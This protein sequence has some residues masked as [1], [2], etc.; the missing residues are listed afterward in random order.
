M[1][2]LVVFSASY[3]GILDITLDANIFALSR[4]Q[5]TPSAQDLSYD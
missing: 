2:P 4:L 5:L 1:L 3:S